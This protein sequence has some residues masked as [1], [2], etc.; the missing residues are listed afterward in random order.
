MCVYT[1]THFLVSL[2]SLYSL[3]LSIT[4]THT[5]SLFYPSF[6]FLS[7]FLSS[8]SSLSVFP[9]DV[10]L[11]SFSLSFL[12]PFKRMLT[13][14]CLPGH[15]HHLIYLVMLT[16]SPTRS[17][18]HS[19]T[20]SLSS[21]IR[22]P[23]WQYPGVITSQSLIPSQLDTS[24]TNSVAQTSTDTLSNGSST[25]PN[26]SQ[27]GDHAQLSNSAGNVNESKFL[28]PSG[29]AIPLSPGL[30]GA[31]S[32]FNS[33]AN[34]IPI[35]P[36]LLAPTVSFSDSYIRPGQLYSPFSFAPHG[37]LHG[38]LPRTPTLPPPSPHAI[39]SCSSFPAL[40]A[41]AH[42]SF[43]T[44]NIKGASFLDDIT[45]IG[46][47]SPF[48]VSPSL[49]PNRRPNGTT[50]FFPTT[51]TAQGE[52]KFATIGEMGMGGVGGAVERLAGTPDDGSMHST[53]SP[54]VKREV[55]SPQRCYID[56]E[57]A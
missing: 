13:F 17:P 37:G 15:H 33:T 55:S 49:S 24:S 25:P 44:S 50:I 21:G 36:T 30:F 28:F 51:I 16:K 47:I 52:A 31:Q 34:N 12:Q 56:Q 40:T 7:L 48:I 22:S 5:L 46:S 29:S 2:C 9:F 20:C 41:I 10:E 18:T 27:N 53:D 23:V 11:V 35:T 26:V 6:S 57:A 54:L 8:L 43:S 38:N 32:F 42:P 4:Y 3:T 14:H 1:V 19:F 39:V 45:K